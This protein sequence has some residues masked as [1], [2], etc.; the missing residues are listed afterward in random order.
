LNSIASAA[1]P[2]NSWDGWEK[3]TVVNKETCPVDNIFCNWDDDF[4]ISV[5]YTSPDN[6]KN[7]PFYIIAFKE[8]RNLAQNAWD[9]IGQ[10]CTKTTVFV[11]IVGDGV[12]D[13][14][15]EIGSEYQHE[16][17]SVEDFGSGY[18]DGLV[19]VLEQVVNRC[20]GECNML[21]E[22][23]GKW[24]AK[25]F[26]LVAKTILKTPTFTIRVVNIGGTFCGNAYRMGCESNFV[27]IASKMCPEYADRH[28]TA[29]MRYYRAGDNGCCAY[30]SR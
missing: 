21:G 11:N 15:R 12:D 28:K 5:V 26:C 9:K 14:I 17:L 7:R 6:R 18:F 29:F 1:E 23:M 22:A 10:D 24:A 30:N 27:G 20:V 16:K 13:V 4:W 19:A 2:L 3:P 8:A 25:I